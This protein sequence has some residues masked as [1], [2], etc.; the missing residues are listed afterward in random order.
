MVGLSIPYL[1]FLPKPGQ[2]RGVQIERDPIRVGLR[3]PVDGGLVGDSRLTLRALLSRLRWNPDR[4][5]MVKAHGEMTE[6]WRGNS[7]GG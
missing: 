1:E 5:F 4:G 7:A 3:Y 6:S 2:A